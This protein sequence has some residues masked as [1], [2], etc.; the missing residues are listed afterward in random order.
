MNEE[1][2]LKDTLSRISHDMEG[3]IDNNSLQLMKDYFGKFPVN[4]SLKTPTKVCPKT[5]QD[6][7]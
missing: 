5:I 2:S 4:T 7:E 3:K 1:M 6:T